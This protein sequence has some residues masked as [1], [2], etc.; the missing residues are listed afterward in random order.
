MQAYYFI[1]ESEALSVYRISAK[2]EEINEVK[3]TFNKG[4]R[5]CPRTQ[6]GEYTSAETWAKCHKHI[7]LMLNRYLINQGLKN[8]MKRSGCSFMFFEKYNVFWI[9]CKL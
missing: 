8:G 7:A 1:S 4:K 3:A 5:A 2:T 9:I 6:R